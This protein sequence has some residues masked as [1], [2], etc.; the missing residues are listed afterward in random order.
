MPDHD[1]V[2]G[3]KPNFTMAVMQI[4]ITNTHTKFINYKSA[5]WNLVMGWHYKR[6]EP[7]LEEWQINR[8]RN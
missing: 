6:E 1:F 8:E 4:A 5:K 7:L 2:A 3:G